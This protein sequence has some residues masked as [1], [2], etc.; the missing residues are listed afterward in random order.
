MLT[1]TKPKGEEPPTTPTPSRRMG[2]LPH[3]L[4]SAVPSNSSVNG[5]ACLKCKREIE[6]S[7]PV[8]TEII[9]LIGTHG[10]TAEVTPIEIFQ[11]DSDSFPISCGCGAIYTLHVRLPEQNGGL[12]K[13]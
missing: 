7:D 10:A 6:I 8:Q 12:L 13:D 9:R 3:K 4:P 5:W 11:P 2:S 1:T